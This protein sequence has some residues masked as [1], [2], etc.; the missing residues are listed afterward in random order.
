LHYEET[1]SLS[2][3]SNIYKWLDPKE[4]Q[5]RLNKKE[6]KKEAYNYKPLFIIN[7]KR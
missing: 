3:Y 2:L 1:Y 7:L 6:N 4:K 5:E